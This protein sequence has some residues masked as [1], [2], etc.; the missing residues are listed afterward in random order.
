MSSDGKL[1]IVNHNHKLA[2]NTQHMNVR[3]ANGGDSIAVLNHSP[4]LGSD[5]QPIMLSNKGLN[6]ALIAW[7][8]GRG[9]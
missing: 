9:A 1:P 8:G 6:R 4:A 3:S 5:R 7:E 2:V